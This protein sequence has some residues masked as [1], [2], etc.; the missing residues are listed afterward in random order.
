L[1][2][3]VCIPEFNIPY[4]IGEGRLRRLEWCHSYSTERYSNRFSYRKG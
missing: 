3:F 1:N 2:A 4:L